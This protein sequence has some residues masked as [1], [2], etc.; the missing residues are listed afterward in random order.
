M[1]IKPV[2]N[3]SDFNSEKLFQTRSSNSSYNGSFDFE[4]L[5]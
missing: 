5:L 1:K 2:T 4:D 3:I